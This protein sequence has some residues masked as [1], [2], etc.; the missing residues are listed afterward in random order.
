[1]VGGIHWVRRG[2][3]IAALALRWALQIVL[4]LLIVLEEWGWRPLADLLGRLARWRP[5]AQLETTIAGLPPYAA[6]VAFAAPSVLLLPLKFLALFLIARG[7]FISSIA[8]FLLAKAVTT[9]LV[10]RL[11]L[12]TQP[13]LMAIGWFAWVYERVMP[14]KEHLT[15][16][17]RTSYVWRTGRVLK[18]RARRAL[19]PLW[20]AMKPELL[21]LAQRARGAA[22]RLLARVRAVAQALR[23]RRS[24]GL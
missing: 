14:W 22:Q 19:R 5:W 24:K 6:L 2:L 4:A 9:A 7:Y 17:V 20:L 21:A 13:K 8:L 11:F 23:S 1:M 10:A 3:K 15:E 12:L 16:M 18:E